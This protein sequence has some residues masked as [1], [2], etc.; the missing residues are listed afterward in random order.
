MQPSRRKPSR[1]PRLG[2]AL[3]LSL[4]L[5]GLVGLGVW[6][7]PVSVPAPA[8][9]RDITQAADDGC[10]LGLDDSPPR[11]RPPRKRPDPD[12]TPASFDVK[13]VEATPTA[14]APSAAPAAVAAAGQGPPGGRAGPAASAGGDDGGGPCALEVGPSARTVVYVLDRSL[15]MGFHG[16]LARARREVLASIRRLPPAARFQVVAYNRDAEP[17]C[18]DGR[19]ELLA[20]DADTL[21]RVAG[22]ISALRASGGT[23]HGR[24][25]RRGLA[26]R[27]D[28]LFLLTDADE[29]GL[30]DVRGVT[31]LNA[32]RAV[33]H[34]VELSGAAHPDGPLHRLAA[35]NGG[36]YRRLDPEE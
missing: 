9:S 15:S 20:P 26:F 2:V 30:D 23:D 35:D 8:A 5:H 6:L 14:L 12:F 19:S 25:L 13:L 21:S 1:L 17:L 33:I 11:P 28:V 27:P 16:A 36:A 31:R 24:A 29:I 4:G 22:A 18:L 3:L 34:A 7:A 32:R 10:T